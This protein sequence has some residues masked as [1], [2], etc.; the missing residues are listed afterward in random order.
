MVLPPDIV[1]DVEEEEVV[2]V[3]VVLS[4]VANVKIVQIL[5]DLVF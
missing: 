3:T 4:V 2:V 1:G 5:P